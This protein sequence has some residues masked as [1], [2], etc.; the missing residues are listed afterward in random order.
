MKESKII[1]NFRKRERKK[2]IFYTVIV[3][4][5]FISTFIFGFINTTWISM[6]AFKNNREINFLEE[7]GIS[8][9]IYYF[10]YEILIILTKCLIFLF[11]IRSEDLTYC[12]RC[13][14]SFVSFLPW[15]F[16][17]IYI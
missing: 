7:F 12:K 8:T 10:V 6:H 2:S 14:I 5:A 13:L 11:I 17:I 9:A 15:V 1:Y 3:Y 16:V 4:F